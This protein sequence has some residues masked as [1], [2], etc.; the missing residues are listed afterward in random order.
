MEEVAQS[1][2]LQEQLLA[3]WLEVP[4]AWLSS[5]WQ[6][7][8]SCDGIAEKQALAIVLYRQAQQQC[9]PTWTRRQCLGVDQAWLSVL[10]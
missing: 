1:P 10:V 5:W 2:R 4:L 3:V 9:R 6:L 7:C 8:C